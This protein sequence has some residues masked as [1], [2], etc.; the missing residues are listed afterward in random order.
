[1]SSKIKA[2]YIVAFFI[3]LFHVSACSDPT[4][5]KKIVQKT[6]EI[7]RVSSEMNK[8][9]AKQAEHHVFLSTFFEGSNSIKQASFGCEDKIYTIIEFKNYPPKLHQVEV[10]WKDPHGEVRELNNFP[11]FVSGEV[12]HAWSSLSLHRSVGAGML[13]WIN[14]AA[15]MEE[16]IGNWTVTVTVGDIINEAIT[17]EVLC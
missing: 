12:A 4:E 1:M 15:G 5:N 6:Q 17:F 9:E 2:T 13:Q 3:L 7:N 10:E 14:P 8:E 11:Y 16:F